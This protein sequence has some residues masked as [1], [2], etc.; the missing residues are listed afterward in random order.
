[1]TKIKL[2]KI[3]MENFMGYAKCEIDFN[4]SITE[5]NGETGIGKTSI[6]MA[7][8]W[9][10][11]LNIEDFAP[12]IDG[13]RI[14]NIATEVFASI[15]VNDI[16]YTLRKTSTQKYDKKTKDFAKN[17]YSYE[18]DGQPIK[19][20]DY[21]SSIEDLFGIEF[22]KFDMLLSLKGFNK[23][24]P[25]K[26]KWTNKRVELFTLV[27]INDKVELLRNKT[28]YDL[29]FK[30]LSKNKDENAIQSIINAEKQTI[31]KVSDKNNDRI[32]E[33]KKEIAEL[34]IINFD[35]IKTK[36]DE[37][38][39]KLGQ[40]QSSKLQSS[41]NTVIES[42]TKL[43]T[44]SQLELSEI[45]DS[46]NQAVRT[47]NDSKYKLDTEIRQVTQ[48]TVLLT[49]K[50]KRIDG[51]IEDCNNDVEY[52]TDLKFD[53]NKGICPQCSQEL[54]KGKKDELISLFDSN[55]TSSLVNAR[56]KADNLAVDKENATARLS[57]AESNL[58]VLESKLDGFNQVPEKASTEEVENKIQ[59]LKNEIENIKNKAVKTEV[60]NEINEC[61]NE[62]DLIVGELAKEKTLQKYREQ[63]TALNIEN[64]KLAND[65]KVRLEK[66][67]QLNDYIQ[68]KVSFV[69][70]EIGKHFDNVSFNFFKWNSA[71]AQNIF[72]CT[73]ECVYQ[74]TTYDSQSTG[75]Q[76]FSDLAVNN[77]LQKLYEVSFP[78][79]IDNFQDITL[80]IGAEHQQIRL[81]TR[82]R[83]KE[84]EN[85]IAKHKQE[86]AE[87]M[88]KVDED[89]LKYMNNQIIT[90]RQ[91]PINKAIRIKDCYTLYDCGVKGE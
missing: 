54:P 85:D 30:D 8:R 48:E 24:N 61:Q 90:I 43:L 66:Q 18:F 56:N 36:K 37:L 51:N 15:S 19:A 72:D 59:E 12:K 49:D 3:T 42:K 52:Y 29:I 58:T 4:D 87:R 6:E 23:D 81:L 57:I 27:D 77:G 14:K 64:K 32:D 82:D 62:Y 67:E 69:N 20:N 2:N 80:D 31:I 68:E 86:C 46:N 25:P 83:I 76:I 78:Q 34:S 60:V 1:M 74:G 53:K 21:Q 40:L 9:V 70:S 91:E 44:A 28:E 63:V 5:I 22:I 89:F 75:Q 73:C 84:I 17:D 41:K 50:I 33:K 13:Y 7:W 79:F 38:L 11:G 88:T 65:E 39:S 71:N 55:K 47:Y 10:L 26:W 45:N 35:S 16:E